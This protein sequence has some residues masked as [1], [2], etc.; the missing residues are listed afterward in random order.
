MVWS[1]LG[2]RLRET[3]QNDEL[4]YQVAICCMLSH[5]SQDSTLSLIVGDTIHSLSEWI[6]VD[7]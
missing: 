5:I 7:G 4:L 2:T 1:F 6:V 3:R